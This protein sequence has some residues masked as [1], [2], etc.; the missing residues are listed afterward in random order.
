MTTDIR[1]LVAQAFGLAADAADDAIESAVKA[2]GETLG[3]VATA[4]GLKS[5]AGSDAIARAA[6]DAAGAVKSANE[7]A[8]TAEAALSASRGEKP[9]PMLVR[10][11]AK[12]ARLQLNGL[13]PV[14]GKPS[15]D[16]LTKI[17]VGDD[18][19]AIAASIQYGRDELID[20]IVDA[21]TDAKPVPLGER[22]GPQTTALAASRGSGGADEDAAVERARKEG[23]SYGKQMM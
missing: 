15:V 5:D 22:T 18:N 2:A 23:A 9:S 17:L 6:T 12:G 16:K 13:I 4:L 19:T 3:K 21:L 7:R 20:Q 1:K 14:L 11:A 8:A 10:Q